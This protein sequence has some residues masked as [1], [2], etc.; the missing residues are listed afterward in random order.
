[1][2]LWLNANPTIFQ[3]NV[4]LRNVQWFT[5]NTNYNTGIEKNGYKIFDWFYNFFTLFSENTHLSCDIS[6]KKTQFCSIW[7]SYHILSF[8]GHNTGLK[9][10]ISY[11]YMG[12][13]KGLSSSMSQKSPFFNRYELNSSPYHHNVE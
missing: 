10:I 12:F 7:C 9:P 3:I 4:L 2:R 13:P 11:I 6:V 5:Q 8:V 1:M